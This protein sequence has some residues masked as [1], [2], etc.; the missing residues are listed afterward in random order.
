MPA[1]RRASCGRCRSE[2]ISDPARTM[3]LKLRTRPPITA[4]DR[5][6]PARGTLAG[7]ASLPAVPTLAAVPA[8]AGG[9]APTTSPTMPSPLC[10]GPCSLFVAD[11]GHVLARP[12]LRLGL[13]VYEHHR[14]G[15]PGRRH[16]YR[17]PDQGLPGHGLRRGG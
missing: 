15:R 8:L 16:P 1:S 9:L 4:S 6:R 13:V 3:M 10:L 2:R 12:G 11:I 7:T 17:G 14:S 5:A